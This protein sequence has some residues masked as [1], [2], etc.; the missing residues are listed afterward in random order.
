MMILSSSSHT[1]ASGAGTAA[2]RSTW[3]HHHFLV[4]FVF[5]FLLSVLSRSLFVFFA[6]LTDGQWIIV[7][8]SIYGIVKLF[9]LWLIQLS[10][11]VIFQ[12]IHSV[13]SQI[14]IY[15]DIFIFHIHQILL[16]CFCVCLVTN[17]VYIFCRP[18]CCMVCMV[19]MFKACFFFAL[20]FII[21]VIRPAQSCFRCNF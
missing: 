5:I 20:F 19:F 17:Y 12:L 1:T 14:Y 8:T 7:P 3:I 15:A 16:H 6:L 21:F 11:T 2:F 18:L 9:L 10:S 13:L 4:G